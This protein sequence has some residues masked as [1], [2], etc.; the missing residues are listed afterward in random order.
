[1]TLYLNVFFLVFLFSTQRCSNQMTLLFISLGNE[2]VVFSHSVETPHV[3]AEPFQDL[4]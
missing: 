3:R 1:M 2:G 4:K